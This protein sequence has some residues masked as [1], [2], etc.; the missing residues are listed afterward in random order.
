MS[1]SSCE[2]LPLSVPP[3]V[4][5]FRPS[6]FN[7][8]L[9][10]LRTVIAVW[11]PTLATWDVPHASSVLVFRP[12][13]SPTAPT[14]LQELISVTD[15]CRLPYHCERRSALLAETMISRSLLR[16]VKGSHWAQPNLTGEQCS[17]L[18]MVDFQRDHWIFTHGVCLSLPT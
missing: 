17:T 4:P 11:S 12:G 10:I 9:T 15:A 14:L 16:P 2:A 5:A 1:A 6:C 13:Q 18:V 3:G 8:T 7:I